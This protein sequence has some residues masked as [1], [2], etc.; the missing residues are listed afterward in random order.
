VSPVG[1]ISRNCPKT[2]KKQQSSGSVTVEDKGTT[3]AV[4]FGVKSADGVAIK[5]TIECN[6]EARQG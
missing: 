5:G 6:S 1:L 2:H 4:R 3:G